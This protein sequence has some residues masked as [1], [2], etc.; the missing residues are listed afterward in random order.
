MNAE[1]TD[2]ELIQDTF[3]K[4]DSYA[5]SDNQRYF[6]ESL[7]KYYKKNRKLSERQFQV[8]KEIRERAETNCKMNS[9]ET[10]KIT[11]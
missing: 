1:M 5:L 6:M 3:R 11:I 9:A 7:Q 2:K 8:L 4:L 10:I